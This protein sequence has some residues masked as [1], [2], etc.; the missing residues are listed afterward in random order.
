MRINNY[1]YRESVIHRLAPG[2]KYSLFL[3]VVLTVPFLPL[4][5]HLL[6]VVLIS[7]G[8]ILAKLPFVY[9]QKNLRFVLYAG[10]FMYVLLFIFPIVDKTFAFILT[11]RLYIMFSTMFLLT[12]TTREIELAKVIAR[13]SRK[14]FK[15]ETAKS[16]T[17]IIL[18]VLNFI[19]LI[20]KE[21]KL[22][23]LSLKSRGLY[24]NRGTTKERFRVIMILV[25]SLVR[26]L[27]V[28]IDEID[29][30][31]YGRNLDIENVN[32]VD[33]QSRFVRRDYVTIVIVTLSVVAV[34]MGGL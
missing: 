23:N 21:I 4:R 3:I 8:V 19:P 1:I 6:E 10:L 7:C 13:I 17:M 16:I 9:F 15:Q 20:I 32:N 12:N 29:L 5:I 28:L 34:Y 31:M 33:F 11:F 27:D 25:E 26:R 18:L 24:L 14:L 22:I 30:V 2:L